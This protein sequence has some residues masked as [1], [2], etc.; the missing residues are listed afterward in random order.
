MEKL[1]C[2]VI[3]A[4]WNGLAA[5][6][7]FICTQ[8]GRTIAVLDRESS[9]GGTWAD[10]RLY[11]GLKSNNLL[12][13]FEYPDF[14][15]TSD[16]F[17][18]KQG[19]HISGYA[20]NTYLKTYAQE[21]GISELVRLQT[22]V[23]TAE[24]QDTE[25]GGWILTVTSSGLD[26]PVQIYAR[27]LIVATGILSEPVL[28]YFKGQSTFGGRIFHTKDFPQIVSKGLGG[29]KAVTIF[30][31][32]KSSWDSVY[33]YATAGVKVNWVIRSTGHG[34]IWMSPP[35]VTPFKQWIEKLANTRF[36]TWFSPCIWG[37]ADGYGRIRKFYHGTTLGRFLV[38]MFWRVLGNDVMQ[39]NKYDSHPKTAKLKPWLD[40]MYV[41]TSFSIL[42]YEQDFFELI[43]SD[44]NL[45]N[46]HI[47]EITNLGPR[48]VHLD[49]GTILE[50]DTLV[51][52]TG[53]DHLP[54]VKFLPEGIEKELGIPSDRDTVGHLLEPDLDS[55]T[56]L[57]KRADE[58]ILQQFPILKTPPVWNKSFAPLPDHDPSSLTPYMLYRFL[59]PTSPRFLR[60][61]D[62]AFIGL[63][64]N[65]STVIT[66]HITALWIS[67]YFSGRLARD[68]STVLTNPEATKQLQY[69]TVLHN[70]FGKW[71]YPADWG[72]KAPKFIFDALPYLD[73]LQHD[74]GICPY[75]KDGIL[76]E[77]TVPYG[78]ED[79]RDITKEW[80][81]TCSGDKAG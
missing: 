3:G 18:V 58:E 23:L 63:Q 55:Q 60:H 34:P 20:I 4:G 70:R 73:M 46:I 33:H 49:D 14:P 53:W 48:R 47:G 15:M 64:S 32:G 7:Q 25:E 27:H 66:S 75:R 43:K 62:T 44:S 54:S 17:D 59:V 36:L 31:S 72:N 21:F 30:G 78:P 76:A 45:V 28:P 37:G 2:V 16:R 1:D 41:A 61:R 12:G 79:Y 67:A 81:E 9:I 71:R 42:N 5:A 29:V 8:P 52:N 38:K 22:V 80:L 19:Q 10:H 13:T 11:D 40:V 35:F 50:C 65:L 57:L 24:H 39:L 51:L 77:M 26:T 6:K 74:L 56:S 69:E 68:P